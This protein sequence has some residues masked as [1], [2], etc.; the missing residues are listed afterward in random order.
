MSRITILRLLESFFRRWWL[1]LVPVLLLAGLGARLV[2]GQSQA[3]RS[4]GSVNVANSTLVATL[5]DVRGNPSF[6]YDTAAGATSKQVNSLLQTD[7]FLRD[8]VTLSLIHI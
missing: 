1:C 8:V 2:M 4:I 6:G 7:Q 5:T 3:Y